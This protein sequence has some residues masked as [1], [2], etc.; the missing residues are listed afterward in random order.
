MTAPLPRCCRSLARDEDIAA[1]RE[2]VDLAN[3][4]GQ[5]TRLILYCDAGARSGALAAHLKSSG[6]LGS[7]VDV[8]VMCGG[9]INYF[10]LGG[11]VKDPVGAV[12]QAVHPG[13][14]EMKPFITRPNKFK[15]F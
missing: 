10:N 15:L 1:L 4:R 9:I 11:C 12:V 5:A 8:A 13:S 3:I 2:R 14:P 6:L 7:S